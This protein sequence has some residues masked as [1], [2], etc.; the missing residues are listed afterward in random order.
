MILADE[1]LRELLPI[2]VGGICTRFVVQEYWYAGV[3]CESVAV[4]FLQLDHGSWHR[5]FIDAG[6]PFWST[7]T[8]PDT[9]D[10]TPDDE[11]HYPQREVAAELG[12]LGLS[13]QNL[14]FADGSPICNLRLSFS[15][16]ITLILCNEND[17]STLIIETDTEW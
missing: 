17:H 9:L 5:F 16:S 14:E 15:G 10:T 11:Y 2:I 3:Q 12:L 6:V 13:V 7:V 4:L 8:E 1:T